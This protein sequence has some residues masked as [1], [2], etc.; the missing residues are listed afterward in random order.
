MTST[1]LRQNQFE[2][3]RLHVLLENTPNEIWFQILM[4]CNTLDLWRLRSISRR[5][6][7]LCLNAAAMKLRDS[8]RLPLQRAYQRI[9]KSN[10]VSDQDDG[11]NNITNNSSLGSN[12]SSRSN[13]TSSSSSSSSSSSDQSSHEV[14]DYD[15]LDHI[16]PSAFIIG[17]LNM[18]KNNDQMLTAFP[19]ECQRWDSKQGVF[20]FQ[21]TGYCSFGNWFPRVMFSLFLILV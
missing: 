5:F 20:I 19:M 21:T 17:K 18:W 13:L 11:N 15:A 8:W 9:Q 16:E 4:K 3:E 1:I 14:E 10:N 7:D 6:K 12:S 2:Q